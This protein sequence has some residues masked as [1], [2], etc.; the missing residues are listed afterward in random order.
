MS[1]RFEH[2]PLPGRVVFGAGR[3]EEVGREVERLGASRAV[4][5][6]AREEDALAQRIAAGL[7]PLAAGRVDGVRQHV[8]EEYA[9]AA[10][11][12]VAQLGADVLVPVGGGSTIG[13]AKAV[14][15]TTGLPILAV[16]TTYAGSEMTP[17]WGITAGARKTTGRDLRVLPR[18][19]VYDPELTLSLPPGLSA[20]SGMNSLAHCVE[21]MWVEAANPLTSAVAGEGIRALAAG[22]PRVVESPGDL[23]ARTEALH[24]AYLGGA[25]LA[26]VGTGLHHKLAHV[27]GGTFDLPHADV[28]SVLLPYTAAFH[29]GRSPDALARVARA[30]EADDAAAALWDLGRAVGAP[31]DLGTLGL[32]AEQAGEAAGIVAEG[33]SATFEEARQIIVWALAGERPDV[34][35]EERAWTRS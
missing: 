25:A 5:V 1:L 18:T 12:R 13:V 21:A 34:R 4:V 26:A 23:E 35:T 30:L 14:A 28:H 6:A 17:I 16:P 31:A 19:V 15:L 11:E 27:L 33:G 9:A 3:V 29:R 22:L 2:E 10:R 20:A 24:G 8:P 32:S 7:G